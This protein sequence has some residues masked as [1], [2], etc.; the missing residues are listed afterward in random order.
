MGNKGLSRGGC[1]D[2]ALEH[3]E[4]VG[5]MVALDRLPAG[6]VG[7]SIKGIKPGMVVDEGDGDGEG[8]W[9]GSDGRM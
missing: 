4:W 3:L 7:L 1:Q 6:A 2:S 8:V 5:W 9:P